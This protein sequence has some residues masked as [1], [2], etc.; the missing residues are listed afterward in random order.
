MSKKLL[1]LIPESIRTDLIKEILEITPIKDLRK[2]LE[3]RGNE[4]SGEEAEEDI[5]AWAGGKSK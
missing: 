5:N 3:E 1:D 4:M 2:A